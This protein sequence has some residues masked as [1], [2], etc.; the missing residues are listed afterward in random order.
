MDLIAPWIDELSALGQKAAPR[1]S[2]VGIGAGSIWHVPLGG[3]RPSVDVIPV[4]GSVF[5]SRS[6]ES[7]VPAKEENAF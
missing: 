1:K 6:E 5:S 4:A 3:I 7:R 2:V